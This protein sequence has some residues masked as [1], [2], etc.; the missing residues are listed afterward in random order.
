MASPFPG[1]DPYLEEP[2]LWPDFHLK[3]L[4]RMSAALTAILPER[5][6]AYAD[7]YVYLE[8][9][10]AER[11]RMGSPDMFL[12]D[13]GEGAT[14]T[15][16]AVA[17]IQAAPASSEAELPA[18]RRLGTRY[19]RIVDRRARRVITVIELLS[20]SNKTAG[21]D[22]AAYLEKRRQCFG[23][24]TNLVE[25]DLLRTGHRPPPVQVNDYR[26]LVSRAVAFP[27]VGMWD[28]SVREPLPIIPI[29][30]DPVD[31]AVALPLQPCLDQ[32]YDES[33]YARDLEYHLP[34]IPPLR[35][36]DAAWAAA[37][38]ASRTRQGAAS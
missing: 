14:A 13:R 31:G 7:R 27:R 34:P 9:E 10:D 38:L 28:I 11:G 25:I 3:M 33:A 35:D 16:T 32:V 5:Y 4:G 17:A 36:A 6:S 29:P 20:P 2:S 15:A 23:T 12:V 26:V 1:M 18:V 24:G 37:L 22:G 30:L 21:A 8:D 19:L